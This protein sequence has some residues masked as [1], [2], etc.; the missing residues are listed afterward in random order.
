M[1]INI[2]DSLN[3][4]SAD[5]SWAR[6]TT[7]QSFLFL[8]SGSA[9]EAHRQ[10]STQTWC[11][12]KALWFHLQ[13]FQHIFHCTQ[14]MFQMRTPAA[15]VA[16]ITL[17]VQFVSWTQSFKLCDLWKYKPHTGAL[18]HLCIMLGCFWMRR[19]EITLFLGIHLH[20]NVCYDNRIDLNRIISQSGYDLFDVL[21]GDEHW[22]YAQ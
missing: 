16:G 1:R 13:R 6:E 8:R 17:T 5:R 20:S 7:R 10:D 9:P 21:C 4:V 14:Q 15:S 2:T 19:W 18:E 22:H 11:W 12:K 3:K